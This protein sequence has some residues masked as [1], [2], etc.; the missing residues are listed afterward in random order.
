MCR[1]LLC[2]LVKPELGEVPVVETG[3]YRNGQ[4]EGLFH[5]GLA[6]RLLHGRDG[7]LH[8]LPPPEGVDVEHGNTELHSPLGGLGD[9][10][11]NVVELEIEKDP[12]PQV[13]D[14]ADDRG[15]EVGKGL[16]ADLVDPDVVPKALD[17]MQGLVDAVAHVQGKDQARTGLLTR[18]RPHRR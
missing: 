18:N 2:R 9:R 7:L 6:G 10:I 11:G 17:P 8:H 4:D 13:L 3:Q 1:K 14:P 16:L 15:P 12:S 5:S